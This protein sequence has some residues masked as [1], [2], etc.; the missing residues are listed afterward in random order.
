MPT[1]CRP[2]RQHLLLCLLLV[3]YLSGVSSEMKLVKPKWTS[4][5]GAISR[6]ACVKA[7]EATKNGVTNTRWSWYALPSGKPPD[8]GWPVYLIFPP[9]QSSPHPDEL[10]QPNATCTKITPVVPIQSCMALLK[11]HCPSA[12]YSNFSSCTSCI[13]KLLET[14]AGKSAY[15]SSNCTE[16]QAYTIWC[17][18]KGNTNARFQNRPPFADPASTVAPCFLPNGSY[19]GAYNKNCSF[20]SMNGQIW[21]QR[22]N[23][24]LLANGIAVVQ[25]NPYS[26]DVWD[27]ATR[28]VWA[29]GL[30]RLFLRELF[31]QWQSGEYGGVG[32]GVLDRRKLLVSGYSVGAQ[33][34]SWFMQ[35]HG[36]GELDADMGAA[37]VAGAMFAGGT[38][39]C[40]RTPS[41]PP[42]DAQYYTHPADAADGPWTH[43]TTHSGRPHSV[44]SVHSVHSAT[45]P[46]TP[47]PASVTLE[48]SL[49]QCKSCNASAACWVVGCSNQVLALTG[50]QPCCQ[51]CCPANFTEQVRRCSKCNS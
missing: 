39:A 10:P 29:A 23:Q 50:R 46:I 41:T 44:H 51:Y 12:S 9:W 31:A 47:T 33:M 15:N 27:W 42:A 19:T 43:S 28:A 22:V 49:H 4:P 21:S 25:V 30:D 3:H 36:S 16:E 45:H 13:D 20:V 38:Y 35:L 6:A 5:F 34:V 48:A 2:D 14:S 11:H 8:G 32:K 37:V 26:K 1:S 17:K 7:P 40:Y 24:Y 18:Y